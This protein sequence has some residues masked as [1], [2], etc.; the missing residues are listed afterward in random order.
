M[1]G[2]RWLSTSGP[3]GQRALVVVAAVFGPPSGVAAAKKA[4]DLDAHAAVQDPDHEVTFTV[5]RQ[6]VPGL[7]DQAA[8]QMFQPGKNVIPPLPVIEVDVRS[9]NVV[10]NVTL[11][12]RGPRVRPR[13]GSWPYAWAHRPPR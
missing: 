13:P 8:A 3:L 7:G 12:I 4:F 1:P 6:S 10:V 5:T 2:C 11:N 9:R